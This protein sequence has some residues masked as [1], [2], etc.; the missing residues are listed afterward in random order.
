MASSLQGHGSEKP[1]SDANADA[2]PRRFSLLDGGTTFCHNKVV[3]SHYTVLTFIPKNLFEQFSKPANRWF[4]LLS[5]L[6]MIPPVSP[7]GGVPTILA[8]LVCIITL[9]A[10]KDALEDWRRHKSDREENERTTLSQTTSTARCSAGMWCDVRVGSLVVVRSNE[11]CPADLVLV[12]SSHQEGYVFVE[13]ANLD[14]ETNLK[15]KQAP[16]GVFT[17]VDQHLDMHDAT[18]TA[19]SLE[20]RIECEGPNEFLYTFVGT[21]RV[22]LK[23]DAEDIVPLGADHV[24]LR[25]CKVKN[26]A[27]CIGFVV[28]TGKETKIMMNSKDK[29]GRKVSHLEKDVGMFTFVM[30]VIVLCLIAAAIGA[31][32]SSADTNLNLTYLGLKEQDGDHDH[33]LLTFVIKFFNFLILF[34]NFIPISLIVSMSF[35]KLIQVFFMYEDV[36]MV[37]ETPTASIHCMPRNSDLNEEMGQVEYVFSDKT[38]TLTCNVMDFRKFFVQGVTYGEGMTEIRRNVLLKMGQ[39]PDMPPEPVPGAK[40]TPHVDLVDRKLDELMATSKGDHYLAVRRFLLHLAINHE[41]YVEDQDASF[42]YSS[43]SPDESAL[44][45]GARHF[46]FTFKSRNNDGITVEL[47]DG[48]FLLV[49]VKVILK[50][51][52]TRKRSSVI[53]EFAERS[54]EGA[55]LPKQLLLFTKGADSVILERLSAEESTSPETKEAI[56]TLTKMS[57]DGL[58]TLCLAGR[59]LQ[60][61]EYDTWFSIYQEA[62]FSTSHR[63]EKIDAAAEEIEK[64]LEL[65]GITGIEDRLQAGVGETV[66]KCFKA[67]IK[68]WML[69]GDKVETAIN[70]SIATG[71]LE[72]DGASGSKFTRIILTTQD[73]EVDGVLDPRLVASHLKHWADRSIEEGPTEIEGTGGTF[74]RFMGWGNG[75]GGTHARS[76]VIY[77]GLVIDGKCLEIALD[78]ENAMNFVAISRAC[79]TVVCCRVSPKQ[80]GAVVRLIRETEKAITL[81]IGDGAND[82]NMIQSANV[83]IGIRGLEGLQ[84]F[85]VCDYGIAQ[86]SFLQDLLFVHGR[87]CYRRVAILVNYTFYKNVVVVMPQYFLG[88]VSGFSGQKLYNDL[89]YQSYNV[90]HSLLPIVLFGVVDQ[91]V[92]RTESLRHPELYE[93]GVQRAYLNPRVSA[94]WLMSGL[95]HALVVFVVP[96]CAMGNGNIIHSDGKANDIWFVGSVVYLLVT[97]VV[98]M[99]VVLETCFLNWIT[100]FGI[101]FSLFWW[102]LLHGAFSGLLTQSVVMSELHGSMLRMFCCPM[103]YLAVLIAV[104]IATMVDFQIKGIRCTFFPTVLQKVQAQVLEE[105]KSIDTTTQAKES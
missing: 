45:Y 51:N 94:G 22:S 71:L 103:F 102:T 65:H 70:I 10:L 37:H 55:E 66:E 68:V 33:V 89:M 50:F 23:G 19:G 77:E 75:V 101:C 11:Y 31:S 87:W 92:S 57:L 56:E 42:T 32:F 20:G 12:T 83:G 3:T 5:V 13:T 36:H 40:R 7:T 8:P 34:S 74:A 91:D 26:V 86:F 48:S 95:W 25:G 100:A 99:V 49:K 79:R 18:Q 85:N 43:S 73:F 59:P 24:L 6:Q 28:Y 88:F 58:R 16:P 21:L 4:L 44:C 90:V 96:Y 41:V 15:T 80:K 30:F 46:G 14:G 60:Q 61:A 52:S 82:C 38:G 1:K 69:T 98:N 47:N 9:N 93:L 97:I 62:S 105:N 76:S 27:W 2:S 17:L 78:P 81:A 104:A 63:Q 39:V 67:G 72:P 84:A 29:K 64:E 35:V 54:P 53:V